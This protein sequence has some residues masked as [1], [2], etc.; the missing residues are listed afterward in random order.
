[1]LEAP[2]EP[3]VLSGPAGAGI[4]VEGEEDGLEPDHAGQP[5]QESVALR[6]IDDLPGHPLIEQAKVAGVAGDGDDGDPVDDPVADV[7]D[8]AFD[9][10]LPL[11]RRALRDDDLVA[12]APETDHLRDQAGRVLQIAV[13][14]DDRLTAGIGEAADRGGGLPEPAR[15]EQE[16]HPW[17]A[18][19]L[20]ADQL[21][22]AVGARISD[23]DDL[24][25]LGHLGEDRANGGQELGKRLLF[26]VNRHHDRKQARHSA[27]HIDIHL[28]DPSARR[29]R[30]ATRVD[31]DQPGWQRGREPRPNRDRTATEPR[32]GC[33]ADARQTE[34]ARRARFGALQTSARAVPG[35]ARAS[36]AWRWTATGPTSQHGTRLAG[37]DADAAAIN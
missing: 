19:V 27:N 7:G 34:M 13:D 8:E 37:L 36:R 22:G 21:D 9:Q 3:V 31:A 10:R 11:A 14:D 25:V 17:V 26:V 33:H 6:Q 32:Q 35:M 29:A 15:K 23:E 24:V 30:T 18:G 20:G 1:N 4:A 5:A 2:R 12:G 16:L 28:A